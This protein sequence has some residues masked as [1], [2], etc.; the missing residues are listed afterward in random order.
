[1]L[2]LPKAICRYVFDGVFLSHHDLPGPV[3][4]NDVKSRHFAS[5]FASFQGLFVF[6]DY[7][8]LL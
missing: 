4:D 3:N 7:F 1:M 8:W 2:E 5:L 6:S